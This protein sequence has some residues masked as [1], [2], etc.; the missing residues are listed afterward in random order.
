MT[1]YGI[2]QMAKKKNI[3]QPYYDSLWG[4]KMHSYLQKSAGSKWFDYLLGKI[5]IDIDKASV[6]R[7][8]D[9]GC[10]VGIH[11]HFLAKNFPKAKVIGY[12]FSNSGIAAAKKNNKSK[13]LSFSIEDITK[14]KNIGK[15]DL[16]TAFDVLEHIEDWKGLVKGLIKKNDRYFIFASPVGRMR[17][18]EKKIGHF[19]NY[20]R[21]EIELFM[22]SQGYKTV[23][24]FYAGF[25]FYSPIVRNL[26]NTFYGR[27]TVG[28]EAEMTKKAELV[29][30]AWYILFRYFSFKSKGDNFIGLFEKERN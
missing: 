29:H 12:D 17:P 14:V 4:D 20:K 18:Y 21:G 9:I 1:G 28:P 3:N 11:T 23:K 16:I 13:N 22:N 2:R 27:N 8:A 15:F 26:T 6:N 25:P 5:I 24:T 10:G 30:R 7:I 19:R